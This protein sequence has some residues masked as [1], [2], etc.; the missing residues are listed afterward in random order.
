VASDGVNEYY[1][2]GAPV[3]IRQKSLLHVVFLVT[4]VLPASANN[5]PQPDGVFSVLLIFPVV[6][7]GMRFAAMIPGSKAK[8]KLLIGLTLT[9]CFI[10][11]LAGTE[12]GLLGLVLIL[13]YGLVRGFQI[14]RRGQGWRPRFV[15]TIVVLWVVFA[16]GDYYASI[17]FAPPSSIALGEAQ[18]IHRL[19]VLST[20][21]SNFMKAGSNSRPTYG[22]ISELRE[23]RLL[24][25]SF[26]VGKIHMG[27]RLGEIV[28]PSKHQF[29]F[30]V[31]PA[32]SQPSSVSWWRL[33]PGSS[34]LS[35]I[36]G[37]EAE[38]FAGERSF[39]VDETGV[40][41]WAMRTGAGPVTREEFVTWQT[42]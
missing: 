6:L 20:A 41:R 35:A 19:R 8:R 3:T 23:A 24:D 33:F 13:L 36:R 22:N 34:L 42:L 2:D 11:T 16:V 12:I 5:P 18:A 26:E 25:S 14:M 40:I 39:A 31:I 32:Q 10:L 7:I 15:G 9:L 30:Y 4:F 21:E 29:V 27:Y 28:E 1:T 17:V 38:Q 37:H